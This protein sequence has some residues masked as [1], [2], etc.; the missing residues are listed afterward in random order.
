LIVHV[1]LELIVHGP[2]CPCCRR[3]HRLSSAIVC[4]RLP[5]SFLS[6]IDESVCVGVVDCVW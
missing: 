5:S 4:H 6:V 1:G 3:P 2:K